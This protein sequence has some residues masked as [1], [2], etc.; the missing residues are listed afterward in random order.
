MGQQIPEQQQQP[1]QQQQQNQQHPELSK[2]EPPSQA[3]Q[4]VQNDAITEF[5]LDRLGRQRPAVFSSTLEEFMFCGSILISMLMS[6]SLFATTARHRT[7]N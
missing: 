3:Q 4:D 1:Q 2:S 6:V 7:L 5:D